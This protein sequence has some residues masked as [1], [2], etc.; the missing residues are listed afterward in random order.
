MADG[1]TGFTVENQGN[2]AV[3]I[4]V[5][6]NKNAAQFLGGSQGG[7]PKFKYWV[8][9]KEIG[10]CADPQSSEADFVTSG[11][12]KVC[13]TSGLNYADSAD[14]IYCYVH[15]FVPSDAAPESKTAVLTFTSTAAS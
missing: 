14:T 4:N 10:S 6:S 12:S 2:I 11:G 8:E 1:E 7:G 5:T 9:E 3:L 13:G 15:I